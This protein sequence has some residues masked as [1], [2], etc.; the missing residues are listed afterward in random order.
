MAHFMREQGCLPKPKAGKVDI[1]DI[2]N[3]HFQARP[4]E[5][6][7]ESLSIMAGT[8]ANGG[9]CPI[10][11]EWVLDSGAVQHILDHIGNSVRGIMF[12]QEFVKIYNFHT[13][14]S[15]ESEDD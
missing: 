12:A 11:G 3:L 2:L 4:P 15:V 1:K 7:C 6:N 13:F 14:Q 5:A 9:K 10:T 8:P